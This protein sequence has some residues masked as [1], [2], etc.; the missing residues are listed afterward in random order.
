MT[1]NNIDPYHNQ[2]SS[3]ITENYDTSGKTIF[4][5]EKDA[6]GNWKNTDTIFQNDNAYT[7]T[8]TASDGIDMLNG[9][10]KI[11]VAANDGAFEARMTG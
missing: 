10:A 8:W 1:H 11:L 9:M 6:N 7:R 5:A 3:S 2:D 4:Q